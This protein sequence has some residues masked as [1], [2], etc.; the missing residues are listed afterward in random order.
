MSGFK[1]CIS[2]KII[3]S[4]L[5]SWR[6]CHY[7]KLKDISQDA[8]NRRSEG[9]ENRINKTFKN[10]VMPHGSRIYYKEYDMAKATMCAYSQSYNSLQHWKCVL[11]CC[12]KCP[13]IN[14]HDQ[15]TDDQYPDNSPSIRFHIYHMIV[16]CTKHGRLL[17]SERKGCHKFQ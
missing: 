7:K 17:L 8:Q 5:L 16:C 4:S 2:D 14:I 3:H 13:S 11:R 10:T 12:A 6:D 15:E 9:K 1:C